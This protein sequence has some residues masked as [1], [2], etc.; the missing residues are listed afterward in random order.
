MV[1]VADQPP[2]RVA[3][4]GEQPQQ[5]Q[6][7]LPMATSDENVHAFTVALRSALPG[8]QA[9]LAENVGLL[10]EMRQSRRE[11]RPG[12]QPRDASLAARVAL[13]A[14]SATQARARTNPALPSQATARV[15]ADVDGQ[16]LVIGANIDA[17]CVGSVSVAGAAGS[18]RKLADRRR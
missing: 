6:P 4:L 7:D 12:S 13:R 16:R 2:G 18:T 10:S 11:A 8:A 17:G 5:P 9:R 15:A 14:E 1:G 3:A